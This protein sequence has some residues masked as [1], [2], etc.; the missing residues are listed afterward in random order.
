MLDADRRCSGACG[1]PVA[2]SARRRFWLI[3]AA[4]VKRQGCTNDAC[5]RIQWDILQSLAAGAHRNAAARRSLRVVGSAQHY[6]LSLAG[7]MVRAAHMLRVAPLMLRVA[8]LMLRVAPL[9]LRVASAPRNSATLRA[10]FDA[11][12]WEARNSG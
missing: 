12:A 2:Y 8:P 7:C 10:R 6:T 5:F 1:V 3:S 11:S 9:M 4:P